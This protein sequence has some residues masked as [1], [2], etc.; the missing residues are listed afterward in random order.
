MGIYSTDDYGT[1][2]RGPKIGSKHYHWL[3]EN[4]SSM[5]CTGLTQDY[6]RQVGAFTGTFHSLNTVYNS[7]VIGSP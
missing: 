3:T 4:A 1:Q 5:F 6:G 7:P 2:T